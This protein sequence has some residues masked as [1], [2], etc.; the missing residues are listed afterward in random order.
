VIALHAT[1][2]PCGHLIMPDGGNSSVGLVQLNI[3]WCTPGVHVPKVTGGNR[4]Q[5]DAGFTLGTA[6]RA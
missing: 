3:G 4:T 6:V 1:K 2:G 5:R